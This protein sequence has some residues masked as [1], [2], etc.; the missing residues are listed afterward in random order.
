MDAPF[1]HLLLATE[2]TEHDLAAE[3]VALALAARCGQPLAA[4]LPMVGNPELDAEAPVLADR[5]DAVAA[6]RR[7][8]LEALAR[9]AGVALSPVVR[10]GPELYAEIVAEA[11]DSKADLL[12]IRRRGRRGLLANLLVGEMVS[13][14]LAHAPC[15]VLVVPRSAT[16]WQRGVLLGVDPVEPVEPAIDTAARLA[17]ACGLPL[18]LV[19]VTADA[20]RAAAE[21]V[22]AAALQRARQWTSDVHG[23]LRGGRVHQALIGAARERGCD[24]VVVG[25][26]GQQSLGRAWVGGTA[27]K[28]VGLAECPVLVHVPVPVLD[29]GAP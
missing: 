29:G 12:V 14:V 22:L 9:H 25:R 24:L 11:Q 27:Q 28:V 17:A 10:R 19:C 20:D 26:H 13:H 2:R 4:V 3:R 1:H 8:E 5:L 23:Q 18:E 15:S 7:G 6:Q 16:L 21:P